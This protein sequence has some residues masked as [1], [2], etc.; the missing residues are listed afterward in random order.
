MKIYR[1]E[2]SDGGGPFISFNGEVRESTDNLVMDDGYLYGC[3]SVE[4]LSQYF[5]PY[6]HLVIECKIFVYNVPL[7]DVIFDKRQ[8]RFP[9][10]YF[11]NKKV[12]KN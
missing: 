12:Y 2:L 10:K 11:L 6:S 9:K 8:V 1:Y 4:K 5:K 3:S 7:E